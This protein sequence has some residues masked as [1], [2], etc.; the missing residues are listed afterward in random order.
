MAATPR[1]DIPEAVIGIVGDRDP[2][3]RTHLATEAGPGPP[4]GARRLRVGAHRRGGATSGPPGPLPGPDHRP[5]QP[6]PRHGGG[7]E[8]PSATPGNGGCRCWAPA[9]GSSTSWWNSPATSLGIADADHAETNP[10]APRLAV[11]PSPAPWPDRATRCGWCPAPGR[12]ALCAARPAVEPFYCNY[13]LNPDYR[14]PLEARGLVVSR[15]RARTAGSGSWNCAGTRS[16]SA[17]CT[18]PRG[19]FPAGGTAPPHGGA[20]GRGQGTRIARSADLA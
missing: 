2:G 4:A 9:A 3:N 1:K 17:P 11:T 12:A 20:G 19:P 18:R 6:V 16:S 15:L 14:A 8:R 5:G 13:G 7:P 10:S